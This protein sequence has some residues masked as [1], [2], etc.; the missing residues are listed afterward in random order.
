MSGGSPADFARRI[1]VTIRP[2]PLR[3]GTRTIWKVP[4]VGLDDFVVIPL[5]F[6]PGVCF[7]DELACAFGALNLD[8]MSALT[9]FFLWFV[10]GD[11]HDA[12]S[13]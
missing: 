7:S 10:L 2:W 3:A 5:S 4:F 6:C 12:N 8:V 13:T 1:P 11:F 9:V